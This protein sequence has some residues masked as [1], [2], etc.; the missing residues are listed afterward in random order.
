MSR[1][2]STPSD[3]VSSA[4]LA[5]SSSTSSRCRDKAAG[6]GWTIAKRLLQHERQ[7]QTG[8][9]SGLGG[10]QRR[11]LRQ[12]AVEYVGVDEQGRPPPPAALPVG[13][14]DDDEL[15]GSGFRAPHLARPPEELA[16]VPG[17]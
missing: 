6:G 14:A 17:V 1:L 12:I 3:A 8:A 4:A 10:G 5:I 11:S 16:Y 2:P 7:S 13:A 15:I 9:T